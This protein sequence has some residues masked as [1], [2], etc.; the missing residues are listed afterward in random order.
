VD[1]KVSGNDLFFGSSAAYNPSQLK[2]KHIVNGNP[3]SVYF[4]VDTLDHYFNI[5]F[6]TAHRTDTVTM[7]LAGKPQDILLF[8]TSLIGQCCPR[9]VLS[10]VSFNGVVV[11]TADTGPKVAILME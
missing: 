4:R 5:A 8:Q 7:Q 2:F 6:P 11:Y 3:D 1:D 10:S 9:L